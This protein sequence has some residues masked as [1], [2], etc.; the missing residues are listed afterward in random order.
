MRVLIDKAGLASTLLCDYLHKL[1]AEKEL[2]VQSVCV[3]VCVCVYTHM[4][5]WSCH[6]PFNEYT[7][8]QGMA[9]SLS[10]LIPMLYFIDSK[11][12]FFSHVL[13]CQI[14]VSY[15]CWCVII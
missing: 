14:A 2:T 5:A 4:H 9:E 6:L 3:C 10:P 8:S 1:L 12:C 13:T 15:I 7:H 11:T